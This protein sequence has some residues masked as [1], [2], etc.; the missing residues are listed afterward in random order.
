MRKTLLILFFLIS[1]TSLKAQFFIGGVH[2]NGGFPTSKLK[3]EVDR[4]M[5]PSISGIVLYEFYNQPFQ[6][7]FELGYGVYGSKLE[8]GMTFILVLMMNSG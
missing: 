8:K 7:G 1:S 5:F 6:A 4:V 3:S 2:L